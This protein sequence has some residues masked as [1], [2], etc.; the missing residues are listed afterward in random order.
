MEIKKIKDYHFAKYYANEYDGNEIVCSSLIPGY[1]IQGFHSHWITIIDWTLKNN[2]LGS[3][4]IS[5]DFT[6]EKFE[7]FN[8]SLNLKYVNKKFIDLIATFFDL[9]PYHVDKIYSYHK[10]LYDKEMGINFSYCN[11]P[12]KDVQL[13]LLHESFHGEE[14]TN[15]KDTILFSN[16]CRVKLNHSDFMKIYKGE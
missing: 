11:L 8:N 1:Q 3:E 13:F 6:E 4:I 5:I 14:R 9:K 12:N 10:I 16:I 7:I 15:Q 2:D